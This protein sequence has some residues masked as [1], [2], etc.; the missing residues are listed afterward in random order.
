MTKTLTG[1]VRRFHHGRGFGFITP[2]FGGGNDLFFHIKNCAGLEDLQ[3]GQ[4]VSFTERPSRT[5]Q[6]KFEA[7]DVELC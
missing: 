4:R 1:T 7:V 6:G 2:D 3:E 5:H